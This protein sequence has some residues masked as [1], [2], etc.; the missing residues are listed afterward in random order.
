M[1]TPLEPLPPNAYAD[2]STDARTH[3]VP[4]LINPDDPPWGVGAGFFVWLS[5][6][7]LMFAMNFLAIIAYVAV[8]G[9]PPPDEGGLNAALQTDPNLT[10]YALVS[11]I[12]THIATLFVVWAVVTNFGKRPFWQ[13]VGWDWSPRFG[14]WASAGLAVLMLVLSLIAIK[15]LG[16]GLKTQLDEMLESSTEARFVTAFLAVAGAPIVEEL[17]YRGVLYPAMQRVVGVFWAII[18]VASLFAFVHVAQYYNNPAVVFAVASLGFVLTYVRAKTGRLLPCFVIHLVFNGI[19]VAAL[20]IEHF[21]EKPDAV[22][23]P[24][25]LVAF[26]LSL[27]PQFIYFA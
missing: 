22:E 21:T 25:G 9:L 11:L 17:V 18:I 24:A 16:S 19:Q 3:D 12:P 5:S 6:V 26:V 8:R 1:S 23:T 20:I 15:L 14:F 27:I 2:F 4:A 13:T 10:L 7:V